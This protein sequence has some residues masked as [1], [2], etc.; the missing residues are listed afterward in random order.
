M[1]WWAAKAKICIQPWS[2]CSKT[3]LTTQTKGIR[4][5]LRMTLIW[6]SETPGTNGN[7]IQTF[8]IAGWS[9]LAFVPSA[10]VPPPWTGLRCCYHRCNGPW[11]RC[12]ARYCEGTLWMIW[13]N[14]VIVYWWA[15][16]F[17]LHIAYYLIYYLYVYVYTTCN[18]SYWFR[19]FLARTC[20]FTR[21]LP[22]KSCNI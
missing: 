8:S 14:I 5:N 12:E 6:I 18:V 16:V 17:F 2:R 19:Y 11:R 10:T 21:Q 20:N 22:H 7:F 15:A 9:P 3:C 4:Q 1:S 13:T